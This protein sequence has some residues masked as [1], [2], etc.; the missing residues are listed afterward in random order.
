MSFSYDFKPH[1]AVIGDIVNSKKIK[2][3]QEVQVKLGQILEEVNLSYS[4]DIAS[5]FMISLGDEFQGLLTDGK[6]VL[7]MITYIEIK[8][9]PVKIRFGVGIGRI[10]TEINP[11]LPFGADGSA[12]HNARRMI[13][14]L[15][16]L[17]N[18]SKAADAHI[19]IASDGSHEELELLLNTVL[20][21][22]TT[23]KGKWTG[24]QREILFDCIL[25]GDNQKEAAARLGINQPSVQK[26][27]SN[28][29]YYTYKKSLYVVS[30]ALTGI[31]VNTDV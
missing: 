27:M 25:N 16:S 29:G 14:S 21:L 4:D 3:R 8:M 2:N 15:K 19:M 10:E 12:Y 30:K 26:A 28:A 17:E 31:K 20:S 23:I 11:A 18:K 1:I 5:K 13:D 7:D 9:H 6:N 24:R 22:C